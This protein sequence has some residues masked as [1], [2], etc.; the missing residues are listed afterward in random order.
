MDLDNGRAGRRLAFD[1][2]GSLKLPAPL[3]VSE[4]RDPGPGL[5]LGERGQHRLEPRDGPVAGRETIGLGKRAPRLDQVASP[6]RGE[7][8]LEGVDVIE[9]GGA[10][11]T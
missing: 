4:G 1:S 3:L 8:A 2:P 5:A 6:C 11:D 7:G 9:S 10:S